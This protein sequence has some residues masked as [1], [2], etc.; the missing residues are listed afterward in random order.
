MNNAEVHKAISDYDPL[1][2]WILLTNGEQYLVPFICQRC[3]NCCR[4]GFEAPCRYFQE[5]NI[6]L[7]Y[8]ERYPMC[9]AFPVYTDFGPGDTECRG[10][11]T[12]G[13]AID[14]LVL[15]VGFRSGQQEDGIFEKPGEIQKAVARLE[16][17]NLP[18]DF[19]DK[20]IEL[21]S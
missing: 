13:K 21:N 12:S 3:G 7:D 15:G 10:Y 17:G 20:F 8:D 9:D 1:F 6:C 11:E 18:K 2:Y 5:P 4:E 19:I 14:A 16:K